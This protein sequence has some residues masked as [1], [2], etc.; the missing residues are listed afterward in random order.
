[1]KGIVL[2]HLMLVRDDI[3]EEMYG[4]YSHLLE[5]LYT[6]SVQLH[7]DKGL[8]YWEMLLYC[9]TWEMRHFFF[10]TCT[11]KTEEVPIVLQLNNVSMPQK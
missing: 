9:F 4:K 5:L 7:I 10:F 6:F 8:I 1:M 3:F 11:E 2:W